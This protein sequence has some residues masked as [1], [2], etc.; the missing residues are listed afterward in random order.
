MFLL[1]SNFIRDND[2]EECGLEMT[3]AQDYEVLGEIKTHELIPDGSN[4]LVTEANKL[5]YIE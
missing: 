2:I 4:Q 3:F 1:F 5:E